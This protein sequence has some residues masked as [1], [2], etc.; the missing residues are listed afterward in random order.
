MYHKLTFLLLVTASALLHAEEAVSPPSLNIDQAARRAWEQSRDVLIAQ[1]QV[2]S[3]QAQSRSNTSFL[4]PNLSANARYINQ[5][6]GDPLWGQ[7]TIEDVYTADITVD[8]FLFGFGRRSAARDASNYLV[9]AASADHDRVRNEATNIVRRAVTD[10]WLARANITINESRVKQR[11]DEV[12]DAK[13]LEAAGS[14]SALDVRLSEINLADS[15]N[16]LTQA[17]SDELIN[18][19]KLAQLLSIPVQVDKKPI[20]VTGSVDQETNV[21]KYL[22]LA[23]NHQTSSSGLTALESRRQAEEANQQLAQSGMYPQLLA[24]ANYSGIGDG[25]EDLNEQWQ[26]GVGLSWSIYDGGQQMAKKSQAQSNIVSLS[27]QHQK[28]IEQR[29][30]VLINAQIQQK[31]L[32]SRIEQQ[33]HVISLAKKNYD[34]TRL[35]YKAGGTTITRLGD[36]SLAL[37]EAKFLLANLQYQLHNLAI[38]LQQFIELE[39]PKQEE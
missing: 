17:Y 30:Q 14:V 10:I 24:T 11:Q 28:L 6:A 39:P 37:E 21:T 13:A 8:Q 12:D 36:S 3:T 1:A 29:Q 38:S 23:K 2:L 15:K 32:L 19:N 31:T 20:S 35:L 26:I 18:L 25:F 4:Y 7:S 33:K 16:S 34:D 27:Q 22:E 5:E 9:L